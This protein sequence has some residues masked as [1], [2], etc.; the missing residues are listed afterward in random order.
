MEVVCG[1]RGDIGSWIELV[2]EVSPGFPGLETEEALKE[3]KNTVL[4]FMGEERA[5]C[6]KIRGEIAGVLLFSVKHNMIC[7]L[8]VSPA[9][10]RAGV[11]S[12]LLAAALE[13]LDRSRDIT[14]STFRDGDEKGVAPR[15]LYRKFG[16]EEGE[17]V[18]EFGYPNQVFVLRPKA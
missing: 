11:A 4:K 5:L 15:A 7:C 16:F 1:G 2:R 8:A 17:L 13:R 3:H 10:R 6:V 12:A 18:E 14:V 9:H